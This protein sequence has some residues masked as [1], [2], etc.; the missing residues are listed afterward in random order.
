MIF[1]NQAPKFSVSAVDVLLDFAVIETDAV[2]EKTI[3]HESGLERA[4]VHITKPKHHKFVVVVHLHR[5]AD[6]TAK[7]DEIT[8][9]LD[10]K[11][12]KLWRH[13]DGQAFQSDAVADALY[14][15][16]SFDRFYITETSY[17]DGLRI[18]FESIDVIDH[19]S[20]GDNWTFTRALTSGASNAWFLNPAT[21]LMEETADV[22]DIRRREAGRISGTSLVGE[23]GTTNIITHPSDFSNAGW[24][25]AGITPTNVTTEIKDPSGNNNASKLLTTSPNGTTTWTSGTTVNANSSFGL[26]LRSQIDTVAGAIFVSGTTGGTD[27]ET[28]S[29]LP[30]RWKFFALGK[31]SSGYTGN[32]QAALRIDPDAT[33]VYAWAG[34]L[35]QSRIT[36]RIID[37]IATVSATRAAEK[38]LVSALNYL[39]QSP[40]KFT[41]SFRYFPNLPIN[42][43][44]SRICWDIEGLP[45]GRFSHFEFANSGNLT[46]S[47]LSPS[48]TI[49]TS[50]NGSFMLDSWDNHIVCVCDSTIANGMK[51]YYNGVLKKTS[52]N[53][54]FTLK[55]VGTNLSVGSNT[56]GAFSAY[57]KID[58][59]L[60][61]DGEAWDADRVLQEYNR[62]VLR[63]SLI[64]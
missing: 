52:V 43:G 16:K 7:F 10:S 9:H 31:D 62:N 28:I 30:D 21:G 59:F 51:V 14:L 18:Q 53:T 57:G 13:R 38:M 61:D 55:P 40:T 17:P 47:V 45:S 15:F 29:I 8:A 5:Y 2:D 48:T 36:T 33:V 64:S 6:P 41:V 46:F 50:I 27:N 49:N 58:E 1:G 20:H 22:A 19:A 60:V 37:P 26:W 56:S 63:K 25:K 39:S 23:P 44:H 12:C 54:A 35:L 11:L 42:F 4:R 34:Q 32:L 3:T 24:V